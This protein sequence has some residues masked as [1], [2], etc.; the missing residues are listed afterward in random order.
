M[1]TGNHHKQA[2]CD[3]VER[4][5]PAMSAIRRR[6][7]AQPELS[8]REE[9]TAR[10]VSETLHSLG[11]SAIRED[12]GGG[13]GV[14]AD[15][16]GPAGAP[17]IA[18]RA[19]MD[20]L[21]IQEQ[22]DYPYRSC[23]P[24]VMHACGHDGHTAGLLGVAAALQDLRGILPVS[25]RLI[26]QPAEETVNG[27]EALCMAGVV[28]GVERIF[29]LHGWPGLDIG[30]IGVRSGPIMASAD[31]F[32]LT[33]RGR[34]GH[35]AYPHTTVDPIVAGSY[36]VQAFQTID[37]REISPLEPVV[38]TVAQFNAGTAHNIIP[39]S[40]ELKGTVRCFS[41]ELRQSLPKR[42][43]RIVAGVCEAFRAEYSFVYSFGT[44][45]TINEPASAALVESV[46]ADVLGAECVV[47]LDQ[48]S[49]GGEDFAFYLERIPGAMFRLG[50]GV[51]SPALHTPRYNYPDE[52]LPV[53]IKML[54]GIALGYGDH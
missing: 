36:I 26:F 16:A 19:D 51:D 25:V 49:M 31:T 29:A 15:L 42:L 20:A 24:G 7:H 46:G 47:T 8:G 35:A 4:I 41:K 17:V 12:F 52:A 11:I 14:I 30:K 6:L 40:A 32:D 27:A 50:V 5:L 38:V 21:P 54:A 34:G 33:V 3:A 28:D 2:V 37:S 53:A 13:Y 48:P 10:L 44:P 18:L 9:R 45:P 43:E 1:S 39:G 22:S 23:V